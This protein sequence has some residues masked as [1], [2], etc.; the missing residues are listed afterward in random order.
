MRELEPEISYL[1]Q[2]Y[3]EVL[4][5]SGLITR[6]YPG[7]AQLDRADG[8]YLQLRQGEHIELTFPGYTAIHEP[9]K[10]WVVAEGYYL[11]INP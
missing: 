4:D 5:S 10:A 1:D 11:P 3:V 2:L 6:L 7:Q 8:T 9:I